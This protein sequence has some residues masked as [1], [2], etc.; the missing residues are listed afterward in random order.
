[1]IT[2]AILRFEPRI[3]L[4]EIV[5]REEDAYQGKIGINVV[6]TIRITNSRDNIVFPFYFQEGTNVHNM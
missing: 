4:E 1:M 2:T 5:I 3:I 6:Y